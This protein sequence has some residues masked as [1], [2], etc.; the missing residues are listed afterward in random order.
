[1]IT[2]IILV[3]AFLLMIC[4]EGAGNLQSSP[5]AATFTQEDGKVLTVCRCAGDGST[6]RRAHCASKRPAT[7]EHSV[8]PKRAPAGEKFR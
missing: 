2:R 6:L 5:F 7:R 3:L 4:A 1:M 8:L